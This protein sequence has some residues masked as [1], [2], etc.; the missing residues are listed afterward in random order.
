MVRSKGRVARC[1]AVAAAAAAL[2]L[3]AAGCAGGDEAAGGEAGTQTVNLVLAS[4][5]V[6]FLP[7][8]V[9]EDKGFFAQCGIDVEETTTKGGADA[10]RA[11]AAGDADVI[12]TLPEEPIAAIAQGA[13]MKIIGAT[14]NQNVYRLYVTDDINSVADFAG[15][16]VGMLSQG[17]GTDIQLQ[18]LLD[19]Q[20]QGVANTQLVA[21]GGNA[22]RLAAVKTGQVKGTLLSQPT[23]VQAEQEG[24][25]HLLD[26][27]DVIP[28]YNHEVLTAT[29]SAIDDKPEAL[30]CF[31]RSVGQAVG[32]IGQNP[33]EAVQI[34]A[35]RTEIA[36]DVAQQAFDFQKDTYPE[37]G[38]A[39]PA[40]LQWTLDALAEYGHMEGDPLTLEDVY[41]PQF[42]G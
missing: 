17:N 34:A 31:M 2:V 22:E 11:A 26:M 8:Y 36:P 27:R 15:Q 12:G 16:R 5:A 6:N 30:D 24:L 28:A 9:A 42:T 21:A 41:D 40:G 39:D 14:N 13:R 32:W 38:A 29:Q 3:V 7:V 18:W 20:G 10:V 33:Q 35:A 23:D 1:T 4:S 37:G 25:K 19:N